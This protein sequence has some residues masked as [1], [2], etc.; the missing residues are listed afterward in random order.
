LRQLQEKTMNYR[1]TTLHCFIDFNA[2]YD[3]VNRKISLKA[4][5]ESNIPQ[6]LNGL[7]RATLKHVKYRVKWR[8][9][10]NLSEPFGTTMG[11][12]QGHALSWILFNSASENVIM[13]P[14]IET[15]GII[16]NCIIK[17]FRY[18]HENTPF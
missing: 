5:K 14:G 9:P 2:T 4:V 6:K 8:T 11:L 15:K 3:I 18:L 10:H 12:R 13:D 16:Y 17:Q 7:I 1:V